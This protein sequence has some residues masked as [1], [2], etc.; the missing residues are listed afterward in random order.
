MA[1]A[2]LNGGASFYA[3]RPI[4]KIHTYC[5]LQEISSSDSED[6]VPLASLNKKA[7]VK[8]RKTSAKTQ[9]VCIIKQA[10]VRI[11]FND[12]L[13]LSLSLSLFLSCEKCVE[14]QDSFK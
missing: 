6:D 9:K 5:P 8:K 1:A 13:H 14:A 3:P 4:I 2:Y 10:Q 7:P 11:V 12:P